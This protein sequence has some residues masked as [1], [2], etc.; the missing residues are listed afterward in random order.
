[1]VIFRVTQKLSAK[2]RI[3]CTAITDSQPSMVEWYC[4]FVIVQRRQFLLFTHALSLFS[5]WAPVAGSTR[6]EFAQMFRRQAADA[7]RD[8]GFSTRDA[9]K[10][11]DD[12]P[13]VFTKAADR[14]VI[15][16]MVDFGKMLRHAVDYEGGPEYLR[17]RAMNDIANESP[18]RKIGMES[19]AEFLRRLL[20]SSVEMVEGECDRTGRD[21]DTLAREI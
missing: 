21:T 8:Y 6:N 20:L 7:L 2:L 4:N 18:M 11:I 1:V 15:G 16:S 12:G 19:P 13:D 9:A 14:S 3:V 5:F 10:V 17:P